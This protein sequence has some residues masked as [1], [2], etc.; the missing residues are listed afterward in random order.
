MNELI[1]ASECEVGYVYTTLNGSS[2]KDRA[3]ALNAINAPESKGVSDYIGKTIN[4]VNVVCHGISMQNE[5]TGEMNNVTRTILI[6]SEGN[7]YACISK[8]VVESLNKIFGIFGLPS[9]WEE[10]LPVIPQRIKA[11]KGRKLILEVDESKL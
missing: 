8:G 4:L 1:K 3:Q 9:S 10:P 11:G 6:D 7:R 2:R 5:E